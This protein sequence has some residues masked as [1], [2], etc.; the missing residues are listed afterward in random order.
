MQGRNDATGVEKG[1]RMALENTDRAGENRA[2]S[3]GD[4]PLMMQA[5]L[6]A[7]LNHASTAV[8]IYRAEDDG[9]D[10]LFVDFNRAAEEIEQ[11]SRADVIGRSVL[12]VFPGVKEFGLFEVFQRVWRTGVP[13]EHPVSVY[14]DARISGWRRNYVCKLPNGQILAVYNDVTPSKRGELVTR[15][16]E[17]CF[18]AISDYAYDW[19]VW[20]S[21][22]GR[23]L[24]TNPAATRISGYSAREI[25]AM[26]DYP[27]P[28]VHEAD[29][30]KIIRAFHDAVAG[31]AGDEQFR[32]RHKEGRLLWVEISW[33]PVFDE[34][35]NSLG[36]RESIRDIT[37][38]K[39]A[40]QAV[41]L[42]EQ[43]KEAILDNMTEHIIHID[44]DTSILWANRPACESVG[45]TREQ[46]IGR[47]C[48]EMPVEWHDLWGNCPAIDAMENQHRIEA[49]RSGPN[50]RTWFIQA[51]P[52]RNHKGEVIGGVEIAL[53]VTRYK[54]M[55]K[56][57]HELQREL[58]KLE[59]QVGAADPADHED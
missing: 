30:K 20:V 43:E 12:E 39:L 50:G 6:D 37:A 29:R 2:A 58:R 23:V 38:R 21:P 35:G 51:A 9:N 40:E 45:M 19:E 44:A 32:L 25:I 22:S 54:R 5:E 55:E 52:V 14:K 7:I 26:L 57:L 27:E 3:P 17:Q 36:H 56:A 42:A 46:V 28:L 41:E 59:A 10:F 18:R 34:K 31:G 53:D 15:M 49:E 16:S 11:L 48:Y 1:Q 13:E 4:Q 33:Q 47:F 24:W 8:V